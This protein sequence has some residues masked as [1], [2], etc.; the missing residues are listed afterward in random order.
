[1]REYTVLALVAAAATVLLELSV[2]RTGVFRDRRY[3][4]TLAICYGFMVAVNGWLTKLSSPIVLYNRNHISG[5]RPIWDIPIE[6]FVFAFPLLTLTLGRWL[7]T[8]GA[9]RGR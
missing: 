3:W 5:L 6:D 4:I 8:G 7:Q 9:A 1:M 2:L